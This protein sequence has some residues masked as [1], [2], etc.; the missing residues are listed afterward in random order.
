M[1]ITTVLPASGQANHWLIIPVI[2]LSLPRGWYILNRTSLNTVDHYISQSGVAHFWEAQSEVRRAQQVA[3]NTGASIRRAASTLDI[4]LTPELEEALNGMRHPRNLSD[5]DY[6]TILPAIKAAT[7]RDQ[8]REAA[9]G[10]EAA[11]PM[12]NYATAATGVGPLRPIR[13][14]TDVESILI[15]THDWRDSIATRDSRARGF[16][17]KSITRQRNTEKRLGRNSGFRERQG[18]AKGGRTMPVLLR[19]TRATANHDNPQ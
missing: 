3:A 5:R 1:L 10:V 19:P 6:F 15:F 14:S 8:D 11:Y 4:R 18:Q 2:L 17:P 9:Y 7:K 13:E 12:G 16:L